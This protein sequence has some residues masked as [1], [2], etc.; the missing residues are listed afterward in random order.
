MAP[1]LYVLEIQSNLD[2]PSSVLSYG[3]NDPKAAIKTWHDKCEFAADSQI[4]C[5]TIMIV[6]RQG[7]I[8][9]GYVESW[10]HAPE[11]TPAQSTPEESTPTQG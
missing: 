5:H 2:T 9:N 6:T 10:T 3:F 7:R 1:D 8:Y 4:F 11:V